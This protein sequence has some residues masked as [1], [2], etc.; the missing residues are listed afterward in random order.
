MKMATNQLPGVNVLLEGPTGTG[1]THSLGTLVETGLEVFYLACEPGLES[2][3][4]FWKD[5]GKPVPENLYWHYL[6]PA[7]AS[8]GSLKAAAKSINTMTLK[9]LADM[10]DPERHKHNQYI[11]LLEVLENFTDQRTGEQFGAV[12]T[13][14]TDRV[15]V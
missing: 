11:K 12:D 6:A 15:L 1:K 3:L 5:R 13:W 9:S 7:T 8:F 14:G 2:L 10:Q 4:G